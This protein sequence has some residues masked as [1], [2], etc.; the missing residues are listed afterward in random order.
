[1][2]LNQVYFWTNTVKDWKLALK[3]EKYKQLIIDCWKSLVD[4]GFIK[5]YG[6]VIMPNHLHVIWEMVGKNGK[7]MPHASFNK[8]SSHLIFRDLKKNHSQVLPYFLVNE[9]GRQLRLWQRDPLAILMDSK[10][11]IAQKLSYIHLNP[12]QERWNLSSTP[13][14]YFWSSARFY[15]RDKDDFGILTHYTERFG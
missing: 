10:V 4:K 5:I 11:K 1:M 2:E 9:Q 12:L 13:E 8:A 14:D 3:P 7:E 15:E 6:F